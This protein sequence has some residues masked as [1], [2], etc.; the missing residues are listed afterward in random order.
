MER[1]LSGCELPLYWE[2][3][4]GNK[5]VFDSS[6]VKLKKLS[7]YRFYFDLWGQFETL[8]NSAAY[9]VWT[10][11]QPSMSWSP[12]HPTWKLRLIYNKVKWSSL[13]Q[14][15]SIRKLPWLGA[16]WDYVLNL[17]RKG[18][19]GLVVRVQV[20]HFPMN[21]HTSQLRTFLFLN[22]MDCILHVLLRSNLLLT[23]SP[24]HFFFTVTY[25]ITQ[26]I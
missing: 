10:V 6:P 18:K 26:T 9:F 5:I 24:F 3:N 16:F 7:S 11:R 12:N 13:T 14:S 1:L 8:T 4:G 21:Q 25:S 2:E 19:D 15:S 17:E 22:L 23:H 20:L